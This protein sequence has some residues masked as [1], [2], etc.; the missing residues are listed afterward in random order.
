MTPPG[1][2]ARSHRRDENEWER[3]GL[4]A[5]AYTSPEMLEL[6]REVLF[7]RHWQVICHI[8]DIP[9]PGDFITCDIAG[10]RALVL[11][12][13]EGRVNAF[14]NLCRHRG[15]RVL[16][17]ERGN[18]R[19]SI[20]CPFH[21]W[22]YNLDGTLR[23]AARPGSLPDLDPVEWGLKPLECEVW[24]GFVFVR[25]QPG[26]QPGVARMMRRFD[27]ELAQYGLADLVPDGKGSWER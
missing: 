12:D 2:V 27:R 16:G 20:V 15:S 14:H 8:G 3:G 23:S 13:A 10:D 7:R 11:R 26:P 1:R 22:V 4:P 24:Q 17:E 18:C 6:E 25:F 5:W 19:N 21:G 9:T